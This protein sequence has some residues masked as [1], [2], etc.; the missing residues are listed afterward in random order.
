MTISLS[1]YQ[2]IR[3]TLLGFAIITLFFTI[4]EW[5][6]TP[7]SGK[8]VVIECL[9]GIAL[10]FAPDAIRK[11]S[12]FYFPK[13]T[14]Y[15]YWFFLAISVFLGSCLHMMDIVPFWDKILHGTSPMLLSMIGYGIITN[16]LQ[17]VSTKKV[18]VWVFL[19]FGFGFAGICGVF[20]EFWEFTWDTIANLNLQRYQ[21]LAGVPYVGRA[22]LMDTMGDLAVNTVGAS[23]IAIYSYI[24]SRGSGEYF[25]IYRIVKSKNVT[26]KD[27]DYRA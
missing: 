7:A 12:H 27:E 13:A 3:R 11:K 2:K 26:P 25:L 10:I 1:T 6:T 22:A 20:W 14:I 8:I 21:T 4:H 17:N 18:P 19:L 15:F 5:L 16:G 9:A 23:I 24:Q